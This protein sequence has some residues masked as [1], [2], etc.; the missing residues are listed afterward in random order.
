MRGFGSE[1]KVA[2]I[3]E[4]DPDLGL[5]LAE[6][7]LAQAREALVARAY[8]LPPGRWEITQP[9]KRAG[10]YGV[11]VVSGLLALRMSIAERATLELLGQG[12][13]LQPW[14]QLGPETS[15]PPTSGW[16]VLERSRVLLLDRDFAESAAPWPEIASALM[17][18]LVLRSRRLCYQLAVNTAPQIE[19]RLLRFGHRGDPLH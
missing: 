15:A 7:D 13:L 9:A 6:P 16:Q 2:R 18:R 4:L 8:E 10:T 14:V 3:L 1:V 11:L 5:S 19:H 17:Y 12:D